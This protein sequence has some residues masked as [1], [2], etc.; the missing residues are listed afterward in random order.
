MKTPLSLPLFAAVCALAA[1]GQT[2]PPVTVRF[3]KPVKGPVAIAIRNHSN[4]PITAY[5]YTVTYMANGRPGQ[6]DG[7]QDTD[8]LFSTPSLGPNAEAITRIG[9]S[10]YTNVAVQVR[11]AVFADGTTFG[12]ATT[13]QKIKQ[14]RLA[15]LQSLDS[16]SSGLRAA[17]STHAKREAVLSQLQAGK[18]HPVPAVRND[19]ASVIRSVSQSSNLDS[20][21]QVNLRNIELARTKLAAAQPG[22]QIAQP[23]AQ[24]N[25]PASR[26]NQPAAQTRR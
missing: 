10:E 13:V 3:T 23:A 20:A 11:A 8:I 1:S 24:I 18:N 25:Q 22:A 26:I 6:I 12:D 21:L 4:V 7:V 15:A 16:L 5:A 14:D 19:Y 9:G 17:R 2:S